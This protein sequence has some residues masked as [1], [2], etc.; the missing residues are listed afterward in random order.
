MND[1]SFGPSL[2]LTY[3][4]LAIA[5]GTKICIFQLHVHNDNDG[6]APH[7]GGGQ[8]T[9]GGGG[10]QNNCGELD[11]T[12]INCAVVENNYNSLVRLL[13]VPT[14]VRLENT[15]GGVGKSTRR[16]VRVSL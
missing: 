1:V 9:R 12:K 3:H 5:A 10:S 6:E 13:F 8:L 15:W 16:E 7:G 4:K 14:I 2:A 11:F